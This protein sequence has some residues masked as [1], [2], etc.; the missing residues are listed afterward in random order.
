[1]PGSR[2]VRALLLIV[3]ALVGLG[4]VML[5]STSSARGAATYSDP[6]YFLKRQLVWLFIAVCAGFVLARFDY[7][8]WRERPVLLGLAIG[9][10]LCMLLLVL[11][12][13]FRVKVGGSCR[14]LRLGPL[15]VQPSEF[16]KIAVVL[17]LAAWAAHVGK[18]I[19]DFRR[20]LLPA[21]LGLGAAA[22]L[23]MLEPDFGT[24]VLLASVGGVVLFAGGARVPH[25]LAAGAAGL[26]IVVLAVAAN[27]N[28]MERV[29]AFW[30][31]EKHERAAHHLAQSKVAFMQGGMLGVGLGKSIQKQHYLP[32]AHTDFILAIIGEELGFLATFFVI[33]LFAALLVCG[34]RIA[35]QAPDTFGRLLA[36]GITMMVAFQATINVGVVT[37]CLPTKGLPLPFISYGGSSLVAS[38]AAVAILMN[39]AMHCTSRPDRHTQPIKDRL[40]QV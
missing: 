7:H 40:R 17:G 20:G 27:P 3:V 15:S 23:V 14:W 25:L 29:R 19:N 24:T 5:A 34:M 9:A 11:I 35:M 38:V 31:P 6:Q 1:M 8:L 16:A 39:V 26:L 22:L 2:I 36:F 18:R 12:P 13:G 30:T 21:L 32:E 10:V 33:S 28:R 37:G 4:I